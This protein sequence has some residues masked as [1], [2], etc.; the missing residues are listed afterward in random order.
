LPVL[1]S[2]ACGCVDDLVVTGRNGIVF[3]VENAAKLAEAMTELSLNESQ[4]TSMGRESES[5]IRP[6]TI[7]RQAE[8]IRMALVRMS[9]ER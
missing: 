8:T 3:P 4:R 9:Y 7:D 2:D 6:W 1:V 5:M